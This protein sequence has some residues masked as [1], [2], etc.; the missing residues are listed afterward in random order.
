MSTLCPEALFITFSKNKEVY[1]G[2]P[3]ITL[4]LINSINS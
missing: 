4:E 2:T 1:K 3:C